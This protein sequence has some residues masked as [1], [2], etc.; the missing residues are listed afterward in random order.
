MNRQTRAKNT[1]WGI[2]RAP[3]E[4]NRHGGTG[5]ALL[6]ARERPIDAATT[7][8]RESKNERN[9]GIENT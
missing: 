2:P 3:R 4:T 8:A 7:R 9:S 5:T 6:D 1:N